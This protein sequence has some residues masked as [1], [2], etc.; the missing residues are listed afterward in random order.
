[1]GEPRRARAD[2]ECIRRRSRVACRACQ[3][4]GARPDRAAPRKLHAYADVLFQNP[5]RNNG[6]RV[7]FFR[8]YQSAPR[9][10]DLTAFDSGFRLESYLARKL[11][12]FACRD[13]GC[14][15]PEYFSLSF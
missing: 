13:S 8:P 3:D 11:H 1:M 15:E 9:K 6:V 5:V 14:T 2:M 12:V 7:T 10:V 4:G